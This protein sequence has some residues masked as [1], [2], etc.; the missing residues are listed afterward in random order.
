MMATMMLPMTLSALLAA[1]TS[2]DAPSAHAARV[3]GAATMILAGDAVFGPT[4][5][6]ARVPASFSLTLGAYSESGAVTFTRIGAARPKVGTYGVR[7]L[8]ATFPG[9]EFH[10]LVS[11][12][13]PQSPVGVFRAVGGTV[14]ITESSDDQVVGRYEIQ[15]VGFFASD[16][17]NEE[18]EITVR[19][20]FSAEPAALASSF[21]ATLGGEVSGQAVGS[22][23]FGEVDASGVRSF[24]LS[25]G[26]HSE[27]GAV[28]FSR[29][30]AGRPGVG[31]YE[32]READPASTGFHA[33]VITGAPAAPTGVYRV[34]RGT[35]MITEASDGRISGTFQLWARGF[36]AG[37]P[38]NEERILSASGSFT[39]TAG[40][41]TTSLT[42]R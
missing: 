14:T 25:L 16:P 7:A 9:N 2:T 39:A 24:T 17:E 4:R 21:E 31:A 28:I 38:D 1:R 36:T 27:Q 20:G 6:G 18:R 22:A 13:G 8:T 33:L 40:S 19:G 15:A 34:V 12:G 11:L 41:G 23:E 26:A 3:T 5:I 30:G 32:V 42:L 37:D 29:Q 35:L 10:A